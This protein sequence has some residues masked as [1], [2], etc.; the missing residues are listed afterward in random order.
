MKTFLIAI[1]P[2]IMMICCGSGPDPGKDTGPGADVIVDI[3][4]VP[5]FDVA[6]SDARDG[7][8]LGTELPADIDVLDV[9]IDTITPD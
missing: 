3:V 7:D 5:I 1:P 8:T 4:D 2:V 9:V 6:V